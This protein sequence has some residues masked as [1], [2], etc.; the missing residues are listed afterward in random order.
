MK[1]PTTKKNQVSII[2]KIK[3]QIKP[4]IVDIQTFKNN[5]IKTRDLL[6]LRKDNV[7]YFDTNGKPLDSGSQKLFERN[8]IP[9]LGLTL[10]L[11]KAKTTKYCYITLP[12][13]EREGLTM[14]LNQITAL[15]KDL[16]NTVDKLNLETVRNC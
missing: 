14:T 15:I 12:I 3:S 4:N 7:A 5:V 2:K 16:R 8:D 13:S 9:K 6:F 1:T 11:G 10:N